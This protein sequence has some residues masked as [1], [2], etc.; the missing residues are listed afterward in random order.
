MCLS[1][2]SVVFSTDATFVPA[3]T[4]VV[5]ATA[6]AFVAI[7]VIL[8]S[9]DTGT[10][11]PSTYVI[12]T[13]PSSSTAYSVGAICFSRPFITVFPLSVMLPKL[14]SAALPATALNCASVAAFVE[15]L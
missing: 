5:A 14:I 13:F 11:L 2:S 9:P 4:S 7:P 6:S 1:V 15:S 12:V 3:A 8:A 10:P